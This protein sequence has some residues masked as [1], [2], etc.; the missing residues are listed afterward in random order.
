MLKT[1]SFIVTFVLVISGCSYLGRQPAP[2]LPSLVPIDTS[3]STPDATITSQ[4]SIAPKILRIFVI[5]FENKD[6]AEMLANPYFGELSKRGALLSQYYGIAHPSQPNYFAMIGGDTFGIFDDGNHNLAQNSVVDLLEAKNVS[7]KSY[8]EDFPGGCFAGGSASALYA[9]KH[10]PFISFDKIRTNP[11]RC[12]KIV[13]AEELQT[14]IAANRLPSFSFYA[15]NVD[16]D[17]HDQPISFGA[18]WL[19]DFLEPKLLDPNFYAGTLVVLITDEGR[20]FAANP[21][22]VPIYA[23]L[24]GQMVSAG[25]VDS[26]HYNHYNLLR[27]VEETFQLG[28]L[29]R[30]DAVAQPFDKCI[31]VGG[32]K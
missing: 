11:A 3:Q 26:S 8:Q 28:T 10:N 5:V 16:N 19:K 22:G 2:A 12:A 29:N 6:Q 13:N 27:T 14:D 30:K 32:C 15:P 20:N 21:T 7:W 31:F 18:N 23:V 9:R 24:L 1:N 25:T 4:S 17:A